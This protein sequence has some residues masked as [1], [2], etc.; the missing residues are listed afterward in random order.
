M[1]CVASCGRNSAHKLETAS[2][3]VGERPDSAYVILRDIDYYDLDSDSL[4]AKYVYTRAIANVRVGRSLI[5]DTLL[6]D[7]ASYYI[8]VG[9]TA[10]WV[11]SL[12]LLS[13]YDIFR[14]NTED[15]INRLENIKS[16]TRNPELLWDTY[17]HLLETSILGQYYSDAYGYADWLLRHTD[18]PEQ[19]LKFSTAK[20]ATHYWQGN[21]RRAVEIMDSVIGTGM[22]EKVNEHVAKEFYN[23]YAEFLDANGQ[24]TEAI[25]VLNRIYPEGVAGEDADKLYRKLSLAQYHA[26]SGHPDKAKALIDN[27]NLD[28]TQSYFELYSAI[29]ML[30]AALDYKMTGTF[31]TDLMHKVAKNMDRNHRLAQFN[32]Q[33]AM[34]SVIELSDDNYRLVMQ[35]QRLWLLVSG[36][37]L[38]AVICGVVV[39]IITSRRKHRLIEAEERAETLERM[40]K[41]YEEAKEGADG[42]SDADKLKATLLRHIGI[43][44]AFAGTPNQQSRDALKRISNIG[45]KGDASDAL[46]DWPDFFSLV[47]NL[48]DGFHAKLIANYPDTFNEK[49]LQIIVLLKADFSTKEISVLTEQS[50]ATIYTRKSVIRKKVGAPENGDIIAEIEN[51]IQ[52]V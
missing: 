35:R 27:I 12:Q 25:A 9:D 15:A 23:E 31:P 4:R 20:A 47:D 24:S 43:F 39:Y 10:K 6:N 33:T 37:L 11:V 50:S 42:I 19:I 49:E 14:G 3:L 44:K 34:E 2:R 21:H 28:G 32:Q 16:V 51:R 46:V 8:S 17:I 30:R 13:G 48:Y 18:V 36:I 40:L 5:T 29:A 52:S 7:A 1:L 22:V 41:E 45:H 26:N 38:L